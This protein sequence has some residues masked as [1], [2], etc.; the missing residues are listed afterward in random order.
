MKKTVRI[1][2]VL[3]AFCMVMSLFAACSSKSESVMTLEDKS[4]SVNTYQLL[5]SRMKGT[6][7]D[8]GY[9][10]SNSTFWRTIISTD[11]TTYDDY[12]TVSV[13]EQA[14]RY[15]IADYLFDLYGLTLTDDRV[16]IV[17][18]LMDAYVKQAGSKN[19]LN[20]TLKSFGANYDILR[21]LLILDVKVSMIKEH[22]Y[23]T[24]GEK[25]DI[26]VKEKY[27]SE[28]YVA[29][30][31]IFISTYSYVPKTD[32][33]NDQVYYTDDNYTA[34]A[35]DTENG[36]PETD[37]FGKVVVD[38]FKNVRYFTAE[39]K[40][41]YDK[42]NGV[43]GY[44]TEKDEDGNVVKKT[45]NMTTAEIEELAKKVDAYLNA[46]NGDIDAF[47]EHAEIYGEG[48]S[49]GEIMYLNASGAYYG[50][51]SEDLVYLD[52]IAENVKKSD[53]YGCSVVQSSYG[54]HLVCRF[55]VEA[56]AYDNESYKDTFSDYYVNLFAELFDE[57]CKEY[58]SMVV[59]DYDALDS[60]PMI[61]EVEVNT[62]Y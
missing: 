15:L 28:N 53:A 49:D 44:E 62:L 12:F 34:I 46:C 7:S 8:Y 2:T 21:E 24:K 16:A 13:Q 18:S 48:E 59:I 32:E 20:A 29:F 38:E 11:G 9:N 55:E 31:Q 4:V 58:E 56:G 3:I 23:G 37:E 30:G 35:Y 50:S 1:I 17:D 40:V 54:F 6:L 26:E 52:N 36:Y 33:F 47:L 5:L 60:A 45:T 39:G 42:V 22:L 25:V 57:K 51:I 41:A 14:S 61:S 19:N 10:V 43:A 27:L